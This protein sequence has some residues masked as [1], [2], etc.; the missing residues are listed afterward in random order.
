MLLKILGDKKLRG[1]NTSSGFIVGKISA[2]CFQEEP[3]YSLA[4]NI[5]TEQEYRKKNTAAKVRYHGFGVSISKRF[6]YGKR[7]RPVIYDRTA[8]AKSYL[9]QSEWWRI[10]NFDLGDK[11]AII[12][13]SHE[14]EWRIPGDL[15]FNLSDV[16]IIVPSTRAYQQFI[17]KCE[18]QKQEDKIL[19]S[20]KGIVQ[21]GMVF[22]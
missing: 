1:S 22:F 7:G 2:V 13:W 20:V 16:S 8:D 12:D 6:A 18:S 19:S 3:L 15:E 21:L 11:D 17:K 9:P 14:R 4:Q 5:Y 10:V